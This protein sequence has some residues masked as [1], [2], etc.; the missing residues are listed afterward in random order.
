MFFLKKQVRKTPIFGQEGGCNIMAFVINLCFAKCEKLSFFLAFVW[1][2][3]GAFQKKNYKIGI[4]AH[5]QQQKLQKSTFLRVIL[6]SKLRVIIWSKLG[7]LKKRKLG[8]D[9]NSQFFCAQFLFPK[10]CAETPIFIVFFGNQCFRANKLG[11]VELQPPIF[12]VVTF[13]LGG[14]G[15]RLLPIFWCGGEVGNLVGRLG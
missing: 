7:A 11:P 3:F 13:G 14:L 12:P 4:L 5:V 15:G 10:K 1:L 6:W 9:N 2:I 8:P